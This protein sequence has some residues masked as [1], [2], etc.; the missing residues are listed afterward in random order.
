M[1]MRTGKLGKNEVAQLLE[2]FP[3][4]PG[5]PWTWDDFS[6]G[7]SLEDKSLEEIRMRCAGLSREFPPEKPNE[8]GNEPCKECYK[9]VIA[10]GS[11]RGRSNQNQST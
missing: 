5:G 1:I 4:G 7:I 11:N 8:Y 3:E 2:A 10:F 9:S 6:Q